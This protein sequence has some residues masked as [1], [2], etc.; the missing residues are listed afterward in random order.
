MST[1]GARGGASVAGEGEMED[2]A[3]ME[4]DSTSNVP[5]LAAGGTFIA[6]TAD[7]TVTEAKHSTKRHRVAEDASEDLLN[8]HIQEYGLVSPE[9]AKNVAWCFFRNPLAWWKQH[10]HLF[11]TLSRLARRYWQPQPRPAL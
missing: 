8:Q 4:E 5:M 3:E 11:P 2:H 9:R 7:A 6:G 10:E 1:A